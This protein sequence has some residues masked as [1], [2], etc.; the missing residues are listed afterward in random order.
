MR[1]HQAKADAISSGRG[2]VEPRVSGAAEG[3]AGRRSGENGAAGDA[4]GPRLDR[5]AMVLAG[6]GLVLGG[7]TS[8]GSSRGLLGSRL[9]GVPWD[10]GG[11]DQTAASSAPPVE[12]PHGSMPGA[13]PSTVPAVRIAG[14]EPRR[15]WGAAPTRTAVGIDPM[16]PIRWIT[17]HH[18]AIE[19]RGRT[20]AQARDRMRLVQ[21]SHQDHRTWADIGYHYVVDPQGRVWEGRPLR[22]QGAHVG[23]ANEGNV[24][25]M[26]MGNFE[27]QT[28]TADQLAGLQRTI[29]ALRRACGVPVQRVRTHREWPHAS[30]ACPGRTLQSGV[31]SLRGRGAFA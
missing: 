3:D 12:T 4:V 25:V 17:I 2:A 14:L 19:Y 24:G 29:I 6:L 7:C 9:P 18:D 22:W 11:R 23:Q 5:R 15:V 21:R 26:L 28:P 27:L 10:A 1:R 8:A 16:L 31:E 20:K 13:A 30:T